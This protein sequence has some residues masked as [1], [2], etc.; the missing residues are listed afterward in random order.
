MKW[1]EEKQIL[2]KHLKKGKDRIKKESFL[3][4]LLLLI[5]IFVSIINIILK[6][7]I[8]NFSICLSYFVL[9]NI[10]KDKIF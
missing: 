9:V 7:S 6:V 4:M 3:K 8:T 2:I 5:Y 1:L 10:E